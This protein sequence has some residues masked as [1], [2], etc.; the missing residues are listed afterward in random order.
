MLAA[1]LPFHMFATLLRF[2]GP[3]LPYYLIPHVIKLSF[4][5]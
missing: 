2:S 3:L 1:P 5:L 4:L